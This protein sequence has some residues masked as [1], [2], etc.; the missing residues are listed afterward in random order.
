MADPTL[1]LE[2]PLLQLLRQRPFAAL[3]LTQFLGALNDNAFKQLVLLLSLSTALPW[4]ANEGWIAQWGQSLALAAFALPFI[5]FGVF[6]G[7]LADRFSKRRVMIASNGAEIVIMGLGGLAFSLQSFALLLIVLFLM[8]TQSAF[9]GPSKYAAI[10]ELTDPRD[11]SRANGVIQMTTS[12]AIVLGMAMGGQVFEAF[13]DALPA[14]A[15]LFASISLVG[16]LASLRLPKLPAMGSGRPLRFNP[17][18]ESLRQWRLI[19]D[20]KPL[21]L[22]ILASAFFYLVGAVLMLVINEYGSWLELSAS[23]ISLLLA[24][25]SLG[26]GLGSLLA[27]SMSGDRI[28]SGLIPA[29][30]VGMSLCLAAVLFAP[31]SENWLRL[32]LFGAG[33]SSG[34]FTIPVRALIQKLPAAED[35][36]SVL[37][38]S[39]MLDFIGIL[40]AAGLFAAM[41]TLGPLSPPQMI[42]A[43]GGLTLLFAVGST[44]Y[45]I[46]FALRFW[47]AFVIRT[48]YKIRTRGIGNIPRRGGA[49]LV[50]NHLSFVD[51]LLVTAAV[52]RPVRFMMY[53]A[54]FDM[55]IIGTFARLVGAIPVSAEDDRTTKQASLEHAAE[56][57]KAGELVCIFAEGGISRSGSLMGFRKGLERISRRA[58]TPIVPVALDGVWGSIFSFEGGRFFWKRPKR[59][60]YPVDVVIG[61][62]L[63]STT[64][65]WQVRDAVQQLI[66]V[67]RSANPR[68]LCERFLISAKRNSKR[69]AVVDSDGTRLTYKKLLVSTLALRSLFARRLRGSH[70]VGI[71]LPP[72]AGAVLAHLATTFAGKLPIHLN[73]SLGSA[74]LQDPIRRAGIAQVVTSPRFLKAL[75]TPSPMSSD[76]TVMLEGLAAELTAWDKLRAAL[77]ASLPLWILLRLVKPVHSPEDTA[78]VLFS[79]GS[80]GTP[81]GVVLSHRN[82]LSNVDSFSRAVSLGPEDSLLGVLPFFHSFG[83]TVT[84]WAPLIYGAKTVY[85]NRPTEGGR[86]AELC[87]AEGVTVC[88][89]TPTFY[90]AWMRRMPAAALASLRLAVT[91]A[92]KLQP[93]FAAA[94]EEKYG[95]HMLEGYGCTELSPCVSVNLPDLADVGQA[96]SGKRA[97]SVGRPLPGVSVR[98]LDQATGEILPPGAE[99]D[100]WVSGPNV[101]GG[102]L[103]DEAR[104]AEVL[105]EGWYDTGDIGLLDRDGFVLLTD[106]R[107]RFAKIAGE[108]VP[109]GRVEECLIEL[110]AD[111]CDA[112][113]LDVEE[114]PEIAVSAVPDDRKGERLVVLHT[115]LPFD[116]QLLTAS[117]SQSQLPV[118]YQ[119]RPDQYYK[120]PEIPKLGTGKTDLKGLKD[121]ALDLVGISPKAEAS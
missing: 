93:R 27:A 40:M 82:V 50:A 68:T 45:T 39:E 22:S 83:Q 47:L 79:S 32:C 3:T 19:R 114:R 85:H 81:K 12:V 76:A 17:F 41:Q 18:G 35:R 64:P 102:Y 25:L 69:T 60:R 62:E 109:E 59:L 105:R 101:M 38:L 97:G 80:T 1:E 90:Q 26:V 70:C 78:T 99:G 65:A 96:Q 110:A 31:L 77:L 4:I 61:T 95:I 73:Y 117:L 29:G 63:P 94:F 43:L 23:S 30:L 75:D 58:G 72:G 24:I 49:L 91:G 71:F 113:G 14:A 42:L 86:I 116:V 53:R 119:P 104:S 108:M 57:L 28:E 74:D 51:A 11:L 34:F 112:A 15:M 37:G 56:L 52:D 111:L 48:V 92:E 121:L 2:V 120:V 9:F 44:C 54:F 100:L 36:G 55:P 98:V 107:S 118:L 67:A 84:L 66:G 87:V 21:V 16:W 33:A 88:L 89:A 10:P 106:R 46:E 7:S 8:G 20:Q 13:G 103:G 5:L 115:P 6:T